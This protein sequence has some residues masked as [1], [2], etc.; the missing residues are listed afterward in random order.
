M[1]KEVITLKDSFSQNVLQHAINRE[2]RVLHLSVT[3]VQG[4]LASWE[5]KYHADDPKS[6]FG[7]VDDMELIEW[8]GE[9]ETLSRLRS[10]L[11]CLEEIQVE[12]R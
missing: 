11:Q 3:Q 1:A 7:K 2:M 6:L 12:S 4:K 10:R 5:G 8:I 9:Q